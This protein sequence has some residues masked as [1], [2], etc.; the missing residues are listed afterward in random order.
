MS[1]CSGIWHI[2]GK[3]GQHRHLMNAFIYIMSG[4]TAMVFF[5]LLVGYS[6]VRG[7][8]YRYARARRLGTTRSERYG[9]TRQSISSAR[10]EEMRD[11]PLL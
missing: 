4:L 6:C 10:F 11:I 7:K 5:G 2:T 9:L 8:S 3:C 1:I